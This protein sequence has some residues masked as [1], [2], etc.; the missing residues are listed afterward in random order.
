MKIILKKDVPKLGNEG[1]IKEVSD[2]FARNYLIP[3]GLA[4]EATKSE[5][6]KLKTKKEHREMKEERIREKSEELLKKISSKHFT[7]KVKAGSSGKL[8]GSVT[9]ADISDKIEE[10]TGTKLD[11]KYINLPENIRE[12]GE[13]KIELELPGSV[14]GT[15]SLTVEGIEG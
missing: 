1:E 5:M 12:T 8:F 6:S 11:K 9:S 15:I 2:G 3:K 14:K 10:D 4:V 13:H 7:I